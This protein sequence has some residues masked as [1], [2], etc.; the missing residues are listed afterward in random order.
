[1]TR[2]EA[3]PSPNVS[4]AGLRRFWLPDKPRPRNVLAHSAL[5]LANTSELIIAA[6]RS[7]QHL[8]PATQAMPMA[9]RPQRAL[10]RPAFSLDGR[11]ARATVDRL[12]ATPNGKP[13][14]RCAPY[15]PSEVRRPYRAPIRRR[16]SLTILARSGRA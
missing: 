6:P 1:M 16:L 13:G 10:G 3:P 9:A 12:R 4:K 15:S 5:L 2:A 14:G 11:V 8:M 7:R